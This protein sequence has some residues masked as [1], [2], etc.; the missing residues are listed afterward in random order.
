MSNNLKQA[1][2]DLKAFAK[3]AKN[4]KYTESL[5]FSYLITGMITFSI[6]INTSS[7]MLYER[8]NKELVMSAEK[9]RVAIKRK[10]QT[11]KL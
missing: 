6:G 3:R 11:K 2:K 7:D 5:L 9:T 4:V 8:M 1:K 10:K